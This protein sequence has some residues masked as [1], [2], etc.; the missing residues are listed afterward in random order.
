MPE[1]GM[2]GAPTGNCVIADESKEDP[3]DPEA[4]AECAS[5]GGIYDKDTGQCRERYY[6]GLCIDSRGGIYQA[7]P[8]LGCWRGGQY[9]QDKGYGGSASADPYDDLQR[10]LSR[11]TRPLDPA[12]T[13]DSSPEPRGGG[14]VPGTTRP[15]GKAQ[16]GPVY[17]QDIDLSAINKNPLAELTMYDIPASPP[18]LGAEDYRMMQR[19]PYYAPMGLAALTRNPQLGAAVNPVSGYNFGFAAGGLTGLP[20]YQAGG[21]LLRGPGDGMSDDIKANIDGEQ[22]ARLA[23]GEFVIPAD[24][25][26]HLGNGSTEA[27]AKA[28]YEMMDRIR[29]ARTGR[30]RQAPEVNVDKYLPA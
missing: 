19:D 7:D 10:Q 3:E 11:I 28:L 26:S 27:G 12:L 21:K 29:K 4:A 8:I 18:R 20:E 24:V 30:T 9:T 23:D 14:Y 17:N 25:V 16:G 15:G 5:R 1:I 13:E 2:D 6:D 22:E